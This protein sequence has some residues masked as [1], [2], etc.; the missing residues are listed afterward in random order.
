[1][2]KPYVIAATGSRKTCV[3]PGLVE[4]LDKFLVDNAGTYDLTV[5]S[6][7]AEG[8][9]E[10]VARRCVALGIPFTAALP[11]RGYGAYYWSAEGSL[12]GQDRTGELNELL[13]AATS[14]RYICG[15]VYGELDGRRL[16]SNFV[17]NQ[18]MVDHAD[19][20]VAHREPGLSRGTDDC[21][22]RAQGADKPWVEF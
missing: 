17:R 11:H 1:M 4:K 8:W 5:I 12:S 2:P 18:W 6:G 3:T 21:L 13:A 15:S 9:D 7:M 16:H 22:R 10:L 14:V 20:L 19:E